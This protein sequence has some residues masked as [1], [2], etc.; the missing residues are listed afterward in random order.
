MTNDELKQTAKFLGFFVGAYLFGSIVD[1][2][3][4]TLKLRESYGAWGYIV[5]I[6]AAFVLDLFTIGVT[7][8]LNFQATESHKL[9]NVGTPVQ[10]SP[11]H[12]S[13]ASSEGRDPRR[14]RRS[15]MH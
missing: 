7:L 10:T 6:V 5:R 15:K 13:L 4:S 2:L 14:D 12:M 1:V 9:R 3:A 8:Y 11:E